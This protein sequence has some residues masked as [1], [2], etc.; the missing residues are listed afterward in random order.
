MKLT[1]AQYALIRDEIW[2]ALDFHGHLEDEDA[3]D[4]EVDRRM[5]SLERRWPE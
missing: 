2:D 1:P 5:A 4:A 3:E